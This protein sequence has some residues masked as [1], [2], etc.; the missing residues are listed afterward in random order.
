MSEEYSNREFADMAGE[1]Q[2]RAG[3]GLI[4]LLLVLLPIVAGISALAFSAT[5]T[6]DYEAKASVLVTFGREYIFRPLRGDEESWA[7]WRAEIAV[8]AE[9]GIL[10]STA[11]QEAAI[12]SVGAN[13]IVSTSGDAADDKP[14]T[15]FRQ[16][17]ASLRDTTAGWGVV[18]SPGD[19]AAV[20]RAMLAEDL[21]VEGVKDSSIVHV[22]FRHTDRAVAVEVVDA[23]LVAYFNSRQEFFRS[24]KDR[25]LQAQLG[26]RTQALEEAG[27]RIVAVR[28]ELGIG[29]FNVTLDGLN[30]REI[31]LAGQID[32]LAGEIAAMKV[33]KKTLQRGRKTKQLLAE[34]RQAKATLGG[35]EA[36]LPLVRSQIVAVRSQQRTLLSHKAVHDTLQQQRDAAEQAYFKILTQINDVQTDAELDAAGLANVKVIQDPVVPTKPVSLPPLALAGLAAG[37]GFMAGLAVIV[38]LSATKAAPLSREPIW[39]DRAGPMRAPALPASASIRLL[40]MPQPASPAMGT[41][42]KYRLKRA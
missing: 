32:R 17:L 33:K 15:L 22:S 9:M 35:L 36:Q 29:D 3:T 21:K 25:I 13:R 28:E 24:P 37:L 38:T 14:S 16:L 7:P 41:A 12:R 18:A 20:A 10:N 31:S 40:P 42:D 30:Q 4:V 1:R 11:L 26:K 8:N 19:A 34:I 27:G 23:L 6:P 5:Q 2:S 39:L